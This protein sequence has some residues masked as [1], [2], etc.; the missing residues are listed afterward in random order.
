MPLIRPAPQ[1]KAA[2]PVLVAASAGGVAWLGHGLPYKLGLVLAA[3]VGVAVGVALDFR[4][5]G[6]SAAEAP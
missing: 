1:L 6:A 4:Q 2:T 5:R 3:L